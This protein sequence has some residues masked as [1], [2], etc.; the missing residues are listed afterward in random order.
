MSN[1]RLLGRWAL[2][3]EL[4]AEAVRPVSDDVDLPIRYQ[5]QAA[6]LAA[7]PVPCGMLGE[8]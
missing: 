2:G 8:I 3:A 1:I 6:R 4:R 7:D 5:I